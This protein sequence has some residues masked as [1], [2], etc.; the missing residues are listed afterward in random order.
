M[1][2]RFTLYPHVYPSQIPQGH[3]YLNS[4]DRLCSWYQYQSSRCA[5]SFL[6]ANAGPFEECCHSNAWLRLLIR[7]IRAGH[8]PAV[9]SVADVFFIILLDIMIDCHI[10]PSMWENISVSFQILFWTEHYLGH[11]SFSSSYAACL[12]CRRHKSFQYFHL[13]ILAI[14]NWLVTWF[15]YFFSLVYQRPVAMPLCATTHFCC[16]RRCC[17]YHS[18]PS[19]TSTG[20]N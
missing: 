5:S 16:C 11:L 18:L 12:N 7:S 9:V 4:F 14:I 1:T 15:V 3:F 17:C 10:N 20:D 6:S 8:A 2:L 19:L 13:R